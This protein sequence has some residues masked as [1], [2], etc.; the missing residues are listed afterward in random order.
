MSYVV[1]HPQGHLALKLEEIEHLHVHEETI[2]EIVDALR[3]E[4]ETTSTI[5]HPIMVDENTHVVL[6]GTHRVQTLQ[7]MG[8]TLIP[9]CLV[10][11]RNPSIEVKSWVRIASSASDTLSD[12]PRDLADWGYRFEKVPAA[13]LPRL[14]RRREAIGM[15]TRESSYVLRQPDEPIE[16]IYATVKALELDCT[17]NGYHVRY[18]ESDAPPRR[19][20]H[21]A[22]IPPR[23]TKHDVL[24]VALRGDVFTH[25]STRHVFPARSL[26]VNV[27]VEWLR[28]P[29]D[30]ANRLFQRTLSAK[31]CTYVRRPQAEDLYLFQ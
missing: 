19:R 11:Y 5:Q 24:T 7:R 4:W 21:A 27:P 23:V 3:R 30:K 1:S 12:P 9:A 25:K 31:R 22:I 28:L 18:A 17:S 20:G 26:S 2:E 10:D 16:A 29:V 14:V 8:C 13:T 6:D 15:K